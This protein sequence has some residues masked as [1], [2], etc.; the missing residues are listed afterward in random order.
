MEVG[1]GGRGGQSDITKAL[2]VNL[3]SMSLLQTSDSHWRVQAGERSEEKPCKE[4][5]W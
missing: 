4:V 1:G 2:C 3:G 5:W